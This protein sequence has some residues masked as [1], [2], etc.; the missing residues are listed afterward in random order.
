[1]YQNIANIVNR[2]E[3]QTPF[4]AFI[5]PCPLSESSFKPEPGP[6]F[7]DGE[8]DNLATNLSPIGAREA[9]KSPKDCAFQSAPC[10]PGAASFPVNPR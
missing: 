7:C 5:L 6:G 4:Q 10:C 8:S 3:K 9:S 1:M 2:T